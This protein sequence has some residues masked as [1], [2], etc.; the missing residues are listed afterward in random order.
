[1][2]LRW[3]WDGWE[4]YE[5]GGSNWRFLSLKWMNSM[6]QD[7]LLK[8]ASGRFQLSF[9]PFILQHTILF[10]VQRV[11]KFIC[12]PWYFQHEN[13]NKFHINHQHKREIEWWK[14]ALQHVVDKLEL[15]FKFFLSL[16]QLLN[17]INRACKS[18]K[19]INGG[20]FSISNA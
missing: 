3:R 10:V 16:L 11:I 18:G 1:M 9:H 6:F 15:W 5:K 14:T 19:S 2:T 8:E 4:S 20:V 7:Y 17:F 12:F 13:L